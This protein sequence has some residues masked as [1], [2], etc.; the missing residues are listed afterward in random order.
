MSTSTARLK[1]HLTDFVFLFPALL[2]FTAIVVVPFING[3]HISLTDWDGYA[4]EYRYVGLRNF[5]RVLGDPRIAGPVRN[6]LLYAALTVVFDNLLG[7]LAALALHRNTRSNRFFRVLVFMPFIISLVLTGFMWSHI[8]S[9]VFYKLL[10]IKSLLG[11]VKTVIPGIA[12]MSMWRDTGYASL[13][14]LAGLNH[15]SPEYYE[16]ARVD[17]AGPVN[18]FFRITLPLLA[19]AITINVTLFLGWGLKV[20]DYVMAATGGG[21]GRSSETVAIYV[22]NYAFPYNQAGYGQ[23]AAILMMGGI[24]IITAAVT[25][26]LRRREVME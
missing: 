3:I 12:I 9:D 6:S 15:I 10:G 26:V 1:G 21:P 5:L 17:G 11:N 7:L 22:Y 14:Y 13:I 2:L 20:F 16:A 8:Y 19:P 24:F 4:P 18:A 23:A 25:A